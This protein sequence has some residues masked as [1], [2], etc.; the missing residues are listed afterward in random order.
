M[1]RAKKAVKKASKKK[2]GAKKTAK[3][4]SKKASK[5]VSKK[6]AKK[7]AK[8][9]A[10]KA[11]KKAVKKP[12]KK[13]TSTSAKG[14]AMVGQKVPDFQ[15]ESTGGKTFQL[16]DMKGKKVVLYFYP[17]DSTPGCTVEGQD[18]TRLHEDFKAQNAEVYGISRDS[19]KSHENFKSKQ[20]Y[21]LD[22]LSDGDEKACQI[23]GVIKEKNMYGRMVLGIERSTFVIDEDGNLVKEW[24][25]VKVPG[26]AEEVLDFIK[27]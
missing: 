18:F 5:K 3:K 15:L 7:T 25:K 26:H 11:S 16:S 8:K 9:V 10:K 12:T 1:A 14:R 13:K 22:L 23:F 21:S 19:M 6:V 27:A 24:R 20:N 17:K 2:T 4:A